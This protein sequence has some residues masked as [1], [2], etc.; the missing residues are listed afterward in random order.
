MSTQSWLRIF[1]C[2]LVWALAST[3]TPFPSFAN[4]VVS[5]AFVHYLLS[6]RY[7]KNNIVRLMSTPREAIS[8][9]AVVLCAIAASRTDMSLLLLFGVHHVCNEVYLLHRN[10]GAAQYGQA[11]LLRASALVFNFAI[12]LAILRRVPQI[13]FIDHTCLFIVLACSCVFFSMNLWKMRRVLTS[14]SL[15]DLCML[16]GL[17]L[18]FLGVSF[19]VDIKLLHIVMYH[20][21]F[22]GLNPIRSMLKQGGSRVLEYTVL[23]VALAAL[24][25]VMS[26]L[27]PLPFHFSASDYSTQFR[28]W[29]FIHIISSFALSAAHPGWIRRWFQPRKMVLAAKTG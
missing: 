1:S 4:V 17:G 9:A 21:I 10:L 5:F 18:I 11:K 7:A 15:I 24:F 2:V 22:W 12:Y 20:F 13:A 25:I 19:F 23:N 8:L 28:F 14:P 6:V 27:G 26:P 3:I 29:S 16:E